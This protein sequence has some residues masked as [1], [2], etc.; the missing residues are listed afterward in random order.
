MNIHIAHDTKVF[1]TL[2]EKIGIGDTARRII[3]RPDV[4]DTSGCLQLCGGQIS[5]IE[6]AVHVVR[7]AFESEENEAVH[8]VDAS[9][10]F[11]SLNR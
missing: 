1:V 4:Q 9:N 3:A 11:N 10:A 6:A 5:G 2:R 7:T 8:L